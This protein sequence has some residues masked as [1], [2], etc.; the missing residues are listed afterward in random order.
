MWGFHFGS[1]FFISTKIKANFKKGVE[2]MANGYIEVSKRNP[3]PICGTGDYCCH[4]PAEDGFGEVYICRRFRDARV[5]NPGGD[6]PSKVDGGFYLFL[7][8][9]PNPK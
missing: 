4:I 1:L 5:I 8:E 6:T 7:S 2:V 9:S 3:C